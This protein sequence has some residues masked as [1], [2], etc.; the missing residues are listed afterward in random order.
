ML[1]S[2]I[3]IDLTG[4]FIG[5]CWLALFLFIVAASFSVKRT[6]RVNPLWHWAWLIFVVAVAFLF[7]IRNDL[8]LPAFM[9]YMPRMRTPAL[10]I[11][12]DIIVFVGLLIALSARIT[13]GRNWNLNP[14][15]KEHHALIED[16]PYG[17]VRHP[18]YTGI[19][20]MFLGA[21]I[22]YGAVS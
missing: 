18:M 6:V 5:L 19:L 13:L 8:R 12:A 17:Y 3:M 4:S 20:L 15:I 21:I 16:G 14:S 10:A 11:V 2:I 1:A 7:I 22:W 9:S